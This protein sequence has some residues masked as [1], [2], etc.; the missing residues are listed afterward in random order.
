MS[1]RHTEFFGA[2][3]GRGPFTSTRLETAAV[4]I[5]A[6]LAQLRTPL[7]RADADIESHADF[8]R[9]LADRLA[10]DFATA[11][12]FDVG[13]ESANAIVTSIRTAISTRS[14]LHCWLADSVGGGETSTAPDSVVFNDGVV[15]EIATASKR[16]LIVTPITGVLSVTVNYVGDRSWYWAT[17]R[18]GRVFYSPILNFD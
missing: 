8:I 13:D 14:L 5:A 12:S 10:P 17:A 15:L 1:G 4:Q 7:K 9:G 2:D 18:H 16:F 6:A 3:L 11:V